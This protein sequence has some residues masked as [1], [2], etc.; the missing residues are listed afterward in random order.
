VREYATQAIIA[1]YARTDPDLATDLLRARIDM[2]REDR[3]LE[4]GGTVT[5]I[6]R[7]AKAGQYPAATN[8]AA[9]A[10]LLMMLWAPGQDYAACQS[11][12]YAILDEVSALLKD[13]HVNA[14][15]FYDAESRPRFNKLLA[16]IAAAASGHSDKALAEVREL[17]AWLNKPPAPT[18]QSAATQPTTG[19]R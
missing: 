11:Q 9:L 4:I 13:G 15:Q 18:T 2:V 6:A 5:A 16:D 12:N 19:G 14:E 3:D 8:E 7:L 17:Q 10:T 1:R